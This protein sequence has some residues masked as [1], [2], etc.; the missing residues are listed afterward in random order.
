MSKWI[1]VCQSA[2]KHKTVWLKERDLTAVVVEFQEHG[3]E[4][5]LDL[6]ESLSVHVDL[7]CDDCPKFKLMDKYEVIAEIGKGSFGRVYKVLRKAD[8]R[9][10]VWKELNYGK[11]Q[12]KEKQMLVTEVNI[13]RD[14]RHPNIVRYYDRIID[15]DTA[16][17]YIVME[18]CAG[19]D[20]AQQI[21]K[22]KKQLPSESAHFPEEQIW[23]LLAQLTSALLECH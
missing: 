21:R 7:V 18:Y 14:L 5:A 23:R 19:G 3:A 16:K 1:L 4:L 10:L 2:A 6:V 22:R 12:E 8:G 20:L 15:K 13:L 11:M 9:Q 17:L